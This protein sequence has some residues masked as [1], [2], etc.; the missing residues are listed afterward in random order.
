M[1]ELPLGLNTIVITLLVG[2]LKAV[3]IPWVARGLPNGIRTDR[4]NNTALS[5]WEITNNYQQCIRMK[6]VE[7]NDLDLYFLDQEVNS[8]T[9]P[10]IWIAKG[11]IAEWLFNLIWYLFHLFRNNP[12]WLATLW[13]WQTSVYIVACCW[14]RTLGSKCHRASTQDCVGGSQ[15]S[16]PGRLLKWQQ[17]I[18]TEYS[19]MWQDR[20]W[21]GP[22]TT[23]Y[24][25]TL[26]QQYG[27]TTTEYSRTT[28][29]QDN[30]RLLKDNNMAK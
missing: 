18:P 6:Y 22:I 10:Y 25:R 16:G 27:K 23:E 30:N 9:S 24:S 3:R 29:W 12:I 26:R 17:S 1:S 7:M 11:Y 15:V 21:Y 28:I 20:Q 4:C 2:C 13:P 14:C 8:C 5:K 19:R